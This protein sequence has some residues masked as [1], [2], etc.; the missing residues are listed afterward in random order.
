ML[1]NGLITIQEMMCMIRIWNI[2]QFIY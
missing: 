1:R 2:I